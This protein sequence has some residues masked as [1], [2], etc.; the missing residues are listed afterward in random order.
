MRICVGDLEANGFLD[1]VTTVWCGVFKDINSGEVWKFGPDEIPKMLKFMDTIDVLIMH[2]GIG[3]D[4]PLLRKLYDYEYKGKKVDTLLMSRLQQPN[5]QRPFG[6]KGRA[7]PHSVEA[8]G[9]RFNRWKPDHEDWTQFSPEMLHRCSE[10]VEIQHLIYKALLEE[11]SGYE[12]GNAWR[13]TFNLF[14]ILERQEEY[15]WLVDQDHL[16]KCIRVLT[17]WMGRINDNLQSRLP[18]LVEIKE[19]KKAGVVGYV[20]KPF[21][22]SGKHNHHMVK[23]WGDDV[24][25][26]RG[27]HS[28]VAFRKVSLDKDKEVKEYLLELGWIPKEWNTNDDG[29]RTSPKL[30]KDDPFEG[31]QGSVGRLIAKRVQCKQRRAICEGWQRRIRDDGRLPSIVTGLA[32]T[33]RAK[34]S[35]IVNVPNEEAFFGKWMR[36]C[37]TC[38]EGR[39][40][41]G[42]DAASCQ[43]RMLADRAKNQD[44]T[45]MLLNG[46]KALGTDGHS[47]AMKAVNRAHQMH[48]F[49]TITRGKAKGYNF[50]YK[51]GAQ[52]PKLGNMGG[53]TPRLGAAVRSELDGVFPAQ[54][55]LRESLTKEWRANAQTSGHGKSQRYKN[56]WIRGLDGRP[57]FIES[58]HA[59]LVYMLQSDEAIVMSAAYIMLYKRLLAK[60]YVWGKDWAYVCWY[61]DEY[62]IECREKI[63]DDIADMA[64]QAI[65]DAG[66][67]FELDHC[68]QVGDAEIGFNWYD[69]H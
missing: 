18:N 64:E 28:R 57:I 62:T 9:R 44:F 34:H 59:I 21:L 69:I 46:D 37:F 23:Y 5:R 40:L 25:L 58:E 50:A 66:K 63:A 43:D 7:G 32:N 8:W 17:K 48:G 11:A 31:I 65:A 26:V 13:M 36:Q 68:P 38:S 33:G 4:W 60:G 47:L 53:G 29:Q 22:N 2:H 30:N 27:P 1:V 52:D 42:C 67:F 51:F 24:H 15:G 54:A 10:D 61:H 6:M 55:A 56:G 45:D 41:I 3:Y 20:K 35:I 12:W 49:N 39:V 19:T 14:E 16:E